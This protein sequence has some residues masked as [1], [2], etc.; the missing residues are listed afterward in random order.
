MSPQDAIQTLTKAEQL[1]ESQQLWYILGRVRN[2]LAVITFQSMGDLKASH[3]HAL[4]A[5]EVQRMR[6][7][8]VWELSGLITAAVM[9]LEM[10]NFSGGKVLLDH[11]EGRYSSYP[12]LD[13][14]WQVTLR[15]Q[16]SYRALRGDWP[17]ALEPL[18][19]A[20]EYAYG[21]SNRKHLFDLVLASLIPVSLEVDRFYEK[22]DWFQIEGLL[23]EIVEVPGEVLNLAGY[24]MMSMVYTRQKNLE[25]AEQ[26]LRK[27]SQPTQDTH[28]F[29]NQWYIK[30]AEIELAVA[31]KDWETAIY[32]LQGFIQ[33]ADAHT[34]VWE[35]ARA[36]LEW[37]DV[38][39]AR[40]AV[41]DLERAKSLYLQSL[42]M[43]AKIGADGYV[44]VL[45]KRLN[46]L[47]VE[48]NEG[49]SPG[50][51]KGGNNG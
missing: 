28:R 9:R 32:N 26:W 34:L 12:N 30:R 19:Q 43:F 15:T 11:I 8:I 4:K 23:M 36:L 27:A 39:V 7:D 50:I 41:G 5:A 33:F 46:E 2:N 21:G 16:G 22:Q 20:L 14:V 38:C 40:R 51:D 45:K 24:A 37:G 18:Y 42:E 29:I 47:H 25:K 6:G 49:I 31:I 17:T 1:A 35:H 3:N 44:K 10:G 13:W 48:V